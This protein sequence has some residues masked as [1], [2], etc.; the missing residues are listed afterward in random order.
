MVEL[1]SAE[2]HV[3]PRMPAT[4]L[5]HTMADA[6]VP[7]ENSLLY[8]AALRKNKIPY[9]MHIYEQ[10][11]HGVGLAQDDPVLRTWPA[12]LADWLA[13][14]HFGWADKNATTAPATRQS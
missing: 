12:L 8:A 10:G 5:F 14:H 13:S 11:R 1:L 7:V 6:G 9:A 4:F 3:T 2:R